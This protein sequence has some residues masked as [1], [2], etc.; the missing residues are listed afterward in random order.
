MKI[1]IIGIGSIGGLLARGLAAAGHRVSVANSRGAQ[2]VQ[3]FA[4]EIGATA[5]DAKGAVA[6]ADLVILSIPLP[7]LAKLPKDLF[8][9]VPQDVPVVDTSNYYPVMRDPQIAELDA[10]EVESLCVSRQIGRP[11]IK[12]FNNILAYSLA[13]F[14]QPENSPGRLAIAVAGDDAR[15]KEIVYG[16]VN[17][18]GFDPVDAGTLAESWRQQP[19]TPAYCCDYDAETM[20]KALA[21]AVGGE[22]PKKRDKLVTMYAGLGPSPTHAQFIELNRSANP[23]S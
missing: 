9:T 5:A 21:M 19:S 22:A 20:R 15:H 14:G 3:S 16:I 2:D 11:V 10:G 17:E 8:D 6:G 4:D 7:A 1:G 13:E 12:A 23:I 18:M